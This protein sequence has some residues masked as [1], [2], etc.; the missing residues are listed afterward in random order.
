MAKSHW[1]LS[2]NLFAALWLISTAMAY[3]SYSGVEHVANT[4]FGKKTRKGIDADT[5]ITGKGIVVDISLGKKKGKSAMST[6]KGAGINAKSGKKE[7]GATSKAKS[8]KK[9]NKGKL[10]G[11]HASLRKGTNGGKKGGN[12]VATSGN[13]NG[14]TDTNSSEPPTLS[15][16]FTQSLPN[17]PTHSTSLN[18]TASPYVTPS[19]S[20]VLNQSKATQAE[21]NDKPELTSELNNRPEFTSELNN[22]PETI[23]EL[24]NTPE[25]MREFISMFGSVRFHPAPEEMATLGTG[26]PDS[27]QQLST[28]KATANN[29]LTPKTRGINSKNHPGLKTTED[30]ENVSVTGNNEEAKK[31]PA[32]KDN[33]PIL[34]SDKSRTPSVPKS[35]GKTEKAEYL[36]K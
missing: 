32:P 30:S 9:T 12:H 18:T 7:I 29:E 19:T 31:G 17:P 2:R 36:G 3:E 23:S 22:R 25:F 8:S 13:G 15:R 20:P 5:S 26:S 11:N 21:V 24:N 27:E 33:I 14:R 28:S 10:K 16:A 34:D 4:A 6:G 35:K 1:T